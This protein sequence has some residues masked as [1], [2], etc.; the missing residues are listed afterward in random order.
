MIK[1]LT[2]HNI[3][4]ICTDRYTVSPNEFERHLKLIRYFNYQTVTMSELYELLVNGNPISR[5]I[6]LTFDDGYAD[7]NK[8]AFPLLK[9]YGMKATVFPIINYIGKKNDWNRNE[10]VTFEHMNWDEIREC[11]KYGMEIGSHTIN[12]LRLNQLTSASNLKKEISSS[13]VILEEKLQLPINSF[14][15]PFGDINPLIKQVVIDAG[16][17]IAVSS[18]FGCIKKAK[19]GYYCSLRFGFSRKE[20]DFFELPRYAIYRYVNRALFNLLMVL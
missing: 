7:N 4:P 6:A 11:L 20:A 3:N 18:N 17:K 8:Y 15:Y 10:R 2:Y 1:I 16:Y 19:T 9:K 14:C 12:H 13:K 5:V